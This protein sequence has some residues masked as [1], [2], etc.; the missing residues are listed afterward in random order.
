MSVSSYESTSIG[1]TL[2]S[3]VS[4][5]LHEQ[6]RSSQS[7]NAGPLFQYS[8][9]LPVYE[10]STYYQHRIPECSS[11]MEYGP[12]DIS[13]R[14]HP[15]EKASTVESSGRSASKQ[16]QNPKPAANGLSPPQGIEHKVA[17]K[18]RRDEL[19]EKIEELKSHIP[20]K[21]LHESM[22]K[23]NTTPGGDAAKNTVLEASIVLILAL[24]DGLIDAYDQRQCDKNSIRALTDTLTEVAEQL[25]CFRV[26]YMDNVN[27]LENILTRERLYRLEPKQKDAFRVLDEN[28]VRGVCQKLGR[29]ELVPSQSVKGVGKPSQITTALGRLET[30]D[31]I[32]QTARHFVL[33]PK[34]GG[35]E[36]MSANAE[37]KP[38][39]CTPPKPL[40]PATTTSNCTRRGK[41]AK[42][43]CNL[44][45]SMEEWPGGR[46][47][48]GESALAQMEIIVR[49]REEQHD[50]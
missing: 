50:T 38:S 25:R 40:A 46:K 42:Q 20:P 6:Q 48:W 41:G 8:R 47:P 26:A 7:P 21:F 13:S 11:A 29:L 5:Q 15:A 31:E 44:L 27:A 22:S 37:S 17:E 4:Y 3:A 12:E 14:R 32:I 24:E 39:G 49:N 35:P 45:Q 28:A 10:G 18:S 16:R 23:R 19:K 30:M 1:E 36:S 34:N 33:D 9:E 2:E 43:S